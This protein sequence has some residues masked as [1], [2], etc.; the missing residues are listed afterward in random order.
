VEKRRAFILDGY[1]QGH[2]TLLLRN[3]A[4]GQR[5]APKGEFIPSEVK[6]NKFITYRSE[7]SVELLV[8]KDSLSWTG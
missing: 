3:A 6:N 7:S 8:S 4:T 5:R 2:F 1:F